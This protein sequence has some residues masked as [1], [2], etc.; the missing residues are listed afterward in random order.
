MK[1]AVCDTY[2]KCCQKVVQ[3]EQMKKEKIMEKLL[4]FVKSSA[5]LK[6]IIFV[7]V[8]KP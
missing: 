2:V 1:I 3:M 7:K 4:K 5:K 8:L 6:L